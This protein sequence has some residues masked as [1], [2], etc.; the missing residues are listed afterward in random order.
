MQSVRPLSYSSVSGL[1]TPPLS[2]VS[3]FTFEPPD[4]PPPNIV[5]PASPTARTHH[6][7]PLDPQ[8]SHEGSPPDARASTAA[9][10]SV[11]ATSPSYTLSTRPLPSR[12]NPYSYSSSPRS[13]ELVTPFAPAHESASGPSLNQAV[14]WSLTGTVERPQR[15]WSGSKWALA[16]M[17]NGTAGAHLGPGHPSAP[18]GLFAVPETVRPARQR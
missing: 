16:G 2:H 10:T 7:P 17:T 1:P 13:I 12:H 5:T 18:G 11:L 6:S 8:R 9:S 4:K 3:A 14:N 15:Q